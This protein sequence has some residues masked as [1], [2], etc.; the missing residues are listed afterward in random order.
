MNENLNLVAILKD[1]PK[2]TKLYSPVYGEVELEQVYA[3]GGTDIC[4]KVKN[5]EYAWFDYKGRQ[6]I[7][8]SIPT[9][10][11]ECLL[12]PSKDQRDWSKFNKPIKRFD[13][14]TLKPFDRVLT[15]GDTTWVANFF[16]SLVIGNEGKKEVVM[17]TGVG[18][19]Y[20]WKQCIPYNNET[21]DLLGTSNDCPEFYKWWK[22]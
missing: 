20:P 3:Y 14:K 6:D 9:L 1:C 21:K 5:M 10:S 7:E 17:A 2:G 19:V 16:G 11:D 8:L 4:V 12:F 22:E 15:K 13:P 18:S